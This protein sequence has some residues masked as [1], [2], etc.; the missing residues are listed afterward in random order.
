NDFTF[1]SLGDKIGLKRVTASTKFKNLIGLGLIEEIPNEKR[2][3]LNYLDKSVS[4]L[5]PYETLRKLN[6]SLNH[7]S[8]SLF[9][10]LL[11]RYIANGEK[12]Y[13][14]TM[15]QMKNFIGIA[16]STTSNNEIITDILEMLQLI[17]LVR[18]EY[19]Q[20]DF[21]KTNLVI[22][23]ISNVVGGIK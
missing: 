19:R 3:K 22:V 13:I 6:N 17:G 7:N 20:T 18:Y 9:V 4:S 21:D 14:V 8:I 23:Q 10:Y 2:Y 5:I 15:A 1:Q 16:S 11:K 12:E